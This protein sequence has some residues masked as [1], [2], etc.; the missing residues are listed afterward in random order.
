MFIDKIPAKNEDESYNVIIEIPMNSPHPIKYELDKE[1]GAIFVD[2]FM[3]AAMFYPCNY[4]FIPGTLS[5]DGDPSDV[6]V[7]SHY[8]IIPGAVIKVRPVG[9]LIMKDEAGMDEKIIAVPTSKIDVTFEPVKDIS[10][11]DSMMKDRIRH[12]FEN[13]KKL[14]KGKWVEVT[15][16]DSANKAKELIQQAIDRA[17]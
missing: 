5:N 3:Q 2:R 16:W 13:Y 8:P 15:G 4:G 14:E 17:R 7:I 6:L 12:F 10:G 9:V 11:I 1:S